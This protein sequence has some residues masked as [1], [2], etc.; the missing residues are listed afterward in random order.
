MII[1]VGDFLKIIKKNIKVHDEALLI[2]AFEFAKEAHKEQKRES[3]APYIIH[4][5]EVAILVS[6]YKLD[7]NS[8]I[9]ALLHDTVEDTDTTM[10]DIKNNFGQEIAYLVDGL[11][12]ISDANFSSRTEK[13]AENFRKLILSTSKDIRIL[14]IK[15]FDRL[16][17]IRTLSG[18]KSKERRDLIANETLMIYVPLAERIGMYK[19]KLELE[20]LC[21]AELLPDERNKIIKQ[22]KEATK[23]HKNIIDYILK[24][25]ITKVKFENKI[26]C[27]IFGRTKRPYS[28]WKKMSR[29]S[30]SFEKIFD[31][32]AFRIIVSDIKDCYKVFGCISTNYVVV[33]DTFDDYISKPKANGYQSIHIIVIGPRNVKIEVQIRTEEMDYLAE[34]GIASHWLYKQNLKNDK[35]LKEYNYLKQLISNLENADYSVENFKDLTCE[36][37]EDEVFC[38]TPLGDIINL[39]T[40]STG[41][42]FAYA[43]HR[44]IGNRCSGIK[45][46]G[47]LS[48]FKTQLKSGDEVE[49]LTSKTPQIHEEWL[50]LVKTAKAKAE[51]KSV[52]R[53]SKQKEFEEIGRKEIKAILDDFGLTINDNLVEKNINKISEGK[54][55]SE[56]YALI[57]QNKIKKKEF[58]KAIFPDFQKEKEEKLDE[59]KKIKIRLQNNNTSTNQQGIEGLDKNIAYKYAKCCYPVPPE[60]I[61]GV[62]NSGVGI[63]VHRK[64]CK[65]LE[66]IEPERIIDLEWNND[67]NAKYVAKVNITFDSK[68]GL[69]A[70]VINLCSEKK[71]NIIGITTVNESDLYQEIEL[72]VEVKNADELNTFKASVRGIRGIIDLK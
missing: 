2:K 1:S 64:T 43:I 70:K 66:T 26:D 3:G 37:Y 14:I 25:L 61:V 50:E 39:P 71:I 10:D 59:N 40:G 22:T 51:I 35:Y 17:N 56:I 42:D 23:N 15:L 49:I 44:D 18:I 13:N 47:V 53:K 11:T 6:E 28:I 45:I 57:A 20:D 4:P 55:V 19:L 34:Y 68:P 65:M 27:Q 46:N 29:K 5:I 62:V 32:I 8:V 38:Y 67:N 30:V 21:F 16:D 58:I 9:A 69:L 72:K 31:L 36:L 7:V 54:T 52:I 60:D 63:T 24:D 41:L 48:Q 12:K 33:P